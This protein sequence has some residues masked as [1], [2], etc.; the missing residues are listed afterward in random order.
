[1]SRK[2]VTISIDEDLLNEIDTKRDLISR[3]K[4]VERVIKRGLDKK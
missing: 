3:S 4:Y 2:E 1:M